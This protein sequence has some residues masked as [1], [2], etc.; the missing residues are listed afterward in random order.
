MVFSRFYGMKCSNLSA[1]ITLQFFCNVTIVKKYSIA[2][3]S[4][5]D[6]FS[7][8]RT[9]NRYFRNTARHE[10]DSPQKLT[11]EKGL[12]KQGLKNANWNAVSN[13]SS[14]IQLA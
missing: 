9:C 2:S 1:Q 6:E 5:V 13:T 4:H 3:D 7:H 11:F 12:L 10:K 14:E 8:N